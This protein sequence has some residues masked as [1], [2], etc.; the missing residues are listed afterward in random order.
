VAL[1]HELYERL[2]TAAKRHFDAVTTAP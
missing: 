2:A 1:F